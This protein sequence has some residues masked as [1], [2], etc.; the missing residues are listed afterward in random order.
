MF[1]PYERETEDGKV[2]LND[3][4]ETGNLIRYYLEE[5]NMIV[6]DSPEVVGL[7]E[8]VITNEQ[9]IDKNDSNTDDVV[10]DVYQR[11][12]D[13]GIIYTEVWYSKYGENSYGT[14]LTEGSRH[15]DRDW[16]V[17]GQKIAVSLTTQHNGFN[18][19]LM[20]AQD[21]LLKFD[22]EFFIPDDYA[23]SLSK[24][25]RTRV[26]WATK[27]DGSSWENDV[28]MKKTTADELLFYENLENIPEGHQ[29]VAAL[30][31][32]RATDQFNFDAMGSGARF[33]VYGTVRN[34]AAKTAKE[35]DKAFLLTHN[36][37]AWTFADIEE[38]TLAWYNKTFED[39]GLTYTEVTQSMFRNF[40]KYM[41]PKH[42]AVD[43]EIAPET[44]VKAEHDTSFFGAKT[45]EEKKAYAAFEGGSY[46]VA[47]ARKDYYFCTKSGKGAIE[48]GLAQYGDY[49][50]KTQKT[51]WLAASKAA[52]YTN[53]VYDVDKSQT[54]NAATYRDSCY[55]VDY[56]PIIEKSV[57]QTTNGVVKDIYNLDYNEATVDYKLT[58]GFDRPGM[59]GT[60]EGTNVVNGWARVLDTIPAGMTYIEGSARL[61]GTYVQDDTY[62]LAGTVSGGVE[63]ADIKEVD[64]ATPETPSLFSERLWKHE[65]GSTTIIWTFWL[66]GEADEGATFYTEDFY[67]SCALNSNELT[68]GQQLENKSFIFQYDPALGDQSNNQYIAYHDHA[69]EGIQIVK[70]KAAAISK[71]ARPLVAEKGEV[72]A[73]DITVDNSNVNP[74]KGV[75]IVDALPV[76]GEEGT[77]FHGKLIVDSLELTG[78][79]RQTYAENLAFYYTTDESCVNCRSK[80]LAAATVT[81]TWT[82][83][84]MGED[85]CFAFPSDQTKQIVAIAAVGDLPGTT[86]LK[87]TLG[88]RLP[89]GEPGDLL[90]N[91]L[92]HG[93]L[94]TYARST[95]VKRVLK[96]LVFLDEEYN[97]VREQSNPLVE[98]IMVSLLK[99]NGQTYE[100]CMNGTTPIATVT[101][102]KG[103]YEFENLLAGTY[104]VAF[105]DGT[106][107][108]SDY[109]ISPK[110]VGS[111]DRDSDA[112]GVLNEQTLLYDKAII[113]D[114]VMPEASSLSIAT[115]TSENHDLGLYRAVIRVLGA[116]AHVIHENKMDETT[117]TFDGAGLYTN[118]IRFGFGVNYKALQAEMDVGDYFSL[119]CMLQQLQKLTG[120]NANFEAPLMTLGID[121]ETG[122]YSSANGKPVLAV[123]ISKINDKENEATYKRLTTDTMIQWTQEMED[124]ESVGKLVELLRAAGLH[125]FN[126]KDNN[127]RIM[128]YL[129]FSDNKTL[130]DT[131]R[132]GQADTEILFR[133]FFVKYDGETYSTSYSLQKANCATRIFN[134]YNLKQFGVP[135]PENE[136]GEG[137]SRLAPAEQ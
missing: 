117:G 67:Y 54:T 33:H 112:S 124:A 98:G 49:Y 62:Q 72:Q 59:A 92:S 133:G 3:D 41:F 11:L 68:N 120:S 135:V 96:G 21:L 71:I 8:G 94:V 55:A 32:F 132:K 107:K 130:E 23:Y 20:A 22:D 97:G 19:Y 115:Y 58:V 113:T 4:F 26:L 90:V 108:V 136:S 53:N 82:K 28:E 36:T 2:H 15:N 78:D 51:T 31:E 84:E 29:I 125:V 119:G 46:P 12:A 127:F 105:S 101:D 99:W 44:F 102:E 81:S 134:Y 103:G 60:T 116:Q 83:L 69:D 13:E 57:A 131:T 75:V 114:I 89:E 66:N 128:T 9:V 65:D 14:Y 129:M 79:D 7:E 63:A 121:S 88:L 16:A 77:N 104:A 111:D 70:L 1:Q 86:T 93:T 109:V 85:Y 10:K 100:P 18:Q 106:T 91:Y 87:M 123:N 5:D 24:G 30:A 43:S 39:V 76:N 34:G 52:V 25:Y 38:C 118:G 42:T 126:V 45:E 110:D 61:G 50:N 27:L 35:N 80:E 47:S 64:V 95:I 56:A 73:F 122:A 17:D 137:A 40:T 74:Q 37:Y 48:N 6:Y